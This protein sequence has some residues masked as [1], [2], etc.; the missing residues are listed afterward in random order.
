MA[1]TGANSIPAVDEQYFIDEQID[2][3]GCNNRYVQ[4][5]IQSLD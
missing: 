4:V 5:L 2:V 1:D 3:D